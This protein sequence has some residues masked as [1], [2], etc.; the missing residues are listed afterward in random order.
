MAISFAR[1]LF[2]ERGKLSP[3]KPCMG[4]LTSMYA[5]QPQTRMS[6]MKDRCPSEGQTGTSIGTIKIDTSNNMNKPQGYSAKWKKPDQTQKSTPYMI[7]SIWWSRVGKSNLEERKK[8]RTVVASGKGADWE[9][10]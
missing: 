7:L 6:I 1:Y 5:W 8:I 9:G 3:Q 2:K 10:E 4:M